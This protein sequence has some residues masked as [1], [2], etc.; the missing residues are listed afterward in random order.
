M[1]RLH[2][3]DIAE[4]VRQ[5]ATELRSGGTSQIEISD[6]AEE[7]RW[8]KNESMDPTHT[9]TNG[10]SSSSDPYEYPYIGIDAEPYRIYSNH[11]DTNTNTARLEFVA[12]A[13][14]V[15]S[16]AEA[17]ETAILSVG[18]EFLP[19]CAIAV[20]DGSEPTTEYWAFLQS[21]TEKAQ[22]EHDA[23]YQRGH[24]WHQ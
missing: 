22:A 14:E 9:A 21:E 20:L 17:E 15:G 10:V 13:E 11:M 18:R 2:P 7:S 6:R 12:A 3:A 4:L 1:T 8:Q 19:P 5:L 24:E 23:E 16:Y